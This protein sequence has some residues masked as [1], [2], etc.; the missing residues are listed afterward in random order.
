[1]LVL[2]L[3]TPAHASCPAPVT[4][5]GWTER[6]EAAEARMRALDP[7]GLRDGVEDA[8]IVV[9][10]LDRPVPQDTAARFH[11]LRGLAVSGSDQNAR[12]RR[13]R[14]NINS[15]T[16]PTSAHSCRYQACAHSANRP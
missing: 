2:A 14:G 4:P 16:E 7:E 11:L 1:M 5:D 10:C 13:V 15:R 12:A 3:L 9:P 6:L 8:L